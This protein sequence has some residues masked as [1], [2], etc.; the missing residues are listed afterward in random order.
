MY[1]ASMAL[2]HIMAQN[3][4]DDDGRTSTYASE[5]TSGLITIHQR[6]LDNSLDLV[7]LSCR[8][9]YTQK[10]WPRAELTS[11]SSNSTLS[12]AATAEVVVTLSLKIK[13]C[14]SHSAT[15]GKTSASLRVRVPAEQSSDQSS[16][17]ARTRRGSITASNPRGDLG[18]SGR[19]ISQ[20]EAER[21]AK[22]LAC[23]S[24]TQENSEEPWLHI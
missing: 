13:Y 20:V 22:Y 17:D 10:S 7:Q 19:S 8:V 1:F 2:S 4:L 5:T 14:R 23:S 21:R 11:A 16:V 12:Q 9:D 3:Q 15:N 24:P 6:T 18:G